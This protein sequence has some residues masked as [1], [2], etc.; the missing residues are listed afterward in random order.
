MI[1]YL[2]D[3]KYGCFECLYLCYWVK[4]FVID[5]NCCVIGIFSCFSYVYKC[6]IDVIKFIS[7]IYMYIIEV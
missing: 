5:V 4:S 3:Y 6:V 2:N 1:L 7:K